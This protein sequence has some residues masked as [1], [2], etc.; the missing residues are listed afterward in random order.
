L[1]K[2]N[3]EFITSELKTLDRRKQREWRKKGK[4]EEYERLKKEFTEKDKKAAN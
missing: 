4:S 3:K 2:K 1:T